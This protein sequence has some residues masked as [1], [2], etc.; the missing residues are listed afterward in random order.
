MK[1]ATTFVSS[2]EA[3][4]IF[5]TFSTIEKPTARP[6]KKSNM[7]FM[8][9]SLYNKRRTQYP[10]NLNISSIKA[11]RKKENRKQSRVDSG[12]SVKMYV[13][14]PNFSIRMQ[15][16]STRAPIINGITY[17]CIEMVSPCLLFIYHKRHR[18]KAK[19]KTIISKL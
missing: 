12:M 18:G 10:S 14:I 3:S 17:S 7:L 6:I 2:V 5:T 15:M 11:H 13:S 8:G 19:D 1:N 16:P 9:L 4:E